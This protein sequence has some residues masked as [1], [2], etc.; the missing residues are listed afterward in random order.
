MVSDR[1]ALNRYSFP[2]NSVGSATLNVQLLG[3]SQATPFEDY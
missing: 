3:Y 1:T 2:Q